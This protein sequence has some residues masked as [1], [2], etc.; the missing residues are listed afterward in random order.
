MMANVDF[1]SHYKKLVQFFWDPEPKNDDPSMNPIWCLGRSY[2]TK[3]SAENLVE[4]NEQVSLSSNRRDMYEEDVRVP[5]QS[6]RSHVKTYDSTGE[7]AASSS[8]EGE[9][10][11]PSDFLDDFESRFWFTYRS[12]FPPIKKSPDSHASS[13]LTLAVRLRSQ[14]IDQGGFTSD[15]GWGCMIRSGQCLIGN[16]LAILR[17]GRGM[18]II[19][20]LKAT[21][22][23]PDW[24]K[25]EKRKEERDLLALFA[26]DPVA[27]FSVHRFVEH[28][29]LACGKHPG[30]WFGPSAA[31]RC[32]ELV[33]SYSE[34]S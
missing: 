9:R 31:A 21:H 19:L 14:L 32:I 7:F 1:G 8:P 30:E 11:W 24:R 16:A 13:S 17:L 4:I 2:A 34:S 10:E 29:S 6:P 28:G 12:H 26:D 5:K 3:G 22:A 20:S 18:S 27:P 15:T 33:N 25:G 23:L